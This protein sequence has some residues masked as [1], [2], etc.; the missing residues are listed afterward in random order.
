LAATLAPTDETSRSV[1][2]ESILDRDF[3]RAPTRSPLRLVWT[4]R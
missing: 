3:W 2:V 4:V 1:D